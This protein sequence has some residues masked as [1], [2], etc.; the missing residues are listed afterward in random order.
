MG[1]FYGNVTLLGTDLDAVRAAAPRPAYAFAE[2]DAVV[3]FAEEDDPEAP[4]SAARLSAELDCIAFSAAVHDDDIFLFEVH[5]RGRSVTGGAVPDPADYFGIDPELLA[6]TD[7]SMLDGMAPS[8]SSALSGPPDPDS[9]V[10]ALGRGDVEA[11][12]A[13][14]E[15]TFLFASERHEAVVAALGIPGGAVGWGYRYLSQDGDGYT[16]PPL[17]TLWAAENT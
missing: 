11:V 12:R 6:G 2:G 1:S 10:R 17:S 14:L 15:G 7:D 16:G 13:A 3:L 9:L 8:T 4:R 5:D